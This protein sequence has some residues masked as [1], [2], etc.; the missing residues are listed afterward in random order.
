VQATIFNLVNKPLFP[1]S[2][3]KEHE[4]LLMLGLLSCVTSERGA[5]YFSAPITSGKRFSLWSQRN[6][7]YALAEH[8]D[9]KASHAREVIEPNRKHAADVVTKMRKTFEA[10]LIDPTAVSDFPGWNQNDY[11]YFWGRVIEI[12][13][14]T[15]V[16]MDGWQYSLGCSYEF[17]VACKCDLTVL[18]EGLLTLDIETGINLITSAI[19][20]STTHPESAGFLS[21]VV[22]HL[23][24]I[25]SLTRNAY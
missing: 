25:K 21:Q 3:D 16:F 23:Y 14:R 5:V 22:T 24:Q 13:A 6:H 12:Y 15:V 4:I 10:V 1:P 17:L 2:T 18:D 8:G 20:D 7:D 19:E 9:Y 11:R